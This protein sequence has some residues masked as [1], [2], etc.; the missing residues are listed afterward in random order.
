MKRG[1]TRGRSRSTASASGRSP[2]S[3]PPLASG[4]SP[5]KGSVQPDFTSRANT[6][7]V[8]AFLDKN[9]TLA[10]QLTRSAFDLATAE[11]QASEKLLPQNKAPVAPP[12]HVRSTHSRRGG[13]AATSTVAA[14]PS[15]VRSTSVEHVGVREVPLSVPSS[16]ELRPG[17]SASASQVAYT[18]GSIPSLCASPVASGPPDWVSGIP[19][20]PS[21][22]P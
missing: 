8:V 21:G 9:K 6:T 17:H 5:S 12:N 1:T 3:P 10:E 15:A 19:L 7:S 18:L 14:R 20:P 16:L 22:P 2:P 11:I 4:G 13:L